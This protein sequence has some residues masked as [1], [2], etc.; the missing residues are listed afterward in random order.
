MLKEL[1]ENVTKIIFVLNKADLL[2]KDDLQKIIQHNKKILSKALQQDEN[3]IQFRIVSNKDSENKNV[4]ALKKELQ[5]LGL[6]EKEELIQ[7][8]SI[9]QLKLL[10]QQATLNLKF[11]RDSYLLPLHEL[12]NRSVQL[13]AS[14]KLMN[15]QK[16][17]F[18]SIINGKIKQLKQNI[19][20]D[21]NEK[22]NELKSNINYSINNITDI[23]STTLKGLQNQLDDLILSS[24]E[25][26]KNN[27]ELKAKEHFKNLLQQYSQRSQSFLHE[28]SENLSAQLGQNME[29]VSAQFDLNA[30]TSFYLSLSSGNFAIEKPISFFDKI[31]PSSYQIKK[32]KTKWLEHYNEIIVR[33]SASVMYD[34]S[35]KIQES[36]RMF[37]YDLNFKM[38]EV[39]K[40]MEKNIG[41]VIENKKKTE[42]RNEEII[43]DL[44]RRLTRLNE[45]EG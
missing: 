44:N 6:D 24:F 18:E 5:N 38:N 41:E 32:I 36:F 8:S 9:H 23:K 29:I 25:K 19:N 7:I 13:A 26:L 22:S 17:E 20:D 10:W 4:D 28:L 1:R 35:Y 15:E 45:F 31:L 42:E 30:Y 11:I 2:S 43:T 34:L 40:S 37:N 16:D 21:V 14:I 12:E 27:W 3:K 33:N 39:L